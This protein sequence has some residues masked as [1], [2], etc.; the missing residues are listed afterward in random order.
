MIKRTYLDKNVLEQAQ[1]IIQS[2]FDT[3][4]NVMLSFSGGKD[5]IVMA[6]ITRNMIIAGKINPKQLEVVFVDEEATFDE[7]VEMVKQWRVKF[8]EL[9]VKFTWYCVE[10]IYFNAFEKLNNDETFVQWD[11]RE[12]ENWVRKPPSYAIM[13]CPYL[14]NR[15]DTYQTWL[16]RLAKAKGQVIMIGLYALESITRYIATASKRGWVNGGFFYP[17]ISWATDDVWYYLKRFNVDYPSVYEDLFRMGLPKNQLRLAPL[18]SID[19]AKHLHMFAE[20]NPELLQRLYKRVP[21]AYLSILYFDTEMFRGRTR[22]KQKA[23]KQDELID[24]RA[25]SFRMLKEQESKEARQLHRFIALNSAKI[26]DNHWR[27]IY[28]I[29]EAGDPKNRAFRQMMQHINCDFK[30]SER[31]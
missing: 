28:A 5:S 18:T 26:Q 3:G 10:N 1:D 21:N 9:G 25:E 8:M 29:L 19:V 31:R 24:Y 15:K 14:I 13:D 4:V 11:K 22:D 6:D 23:E 27:M 7:P 16:P 17:L 30:R 12:K 20:Q 2:V